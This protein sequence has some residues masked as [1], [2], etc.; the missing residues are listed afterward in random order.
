M[1]EL[2]RQDGGVA[3]LM[4]VTGKVCTDELFSTTRL[5]THQP[6]YKHTQ[7]DTRT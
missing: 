7:T 5:A 6:L 2:T 4:L 3:V 1:R